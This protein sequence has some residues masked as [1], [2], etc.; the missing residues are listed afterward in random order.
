MNKM[1]I[2]I[3]ERIYQNVVLLALASIFIVSISLSAYADSPQVLMKAQ[4]SKNSVYCCEC[5]TL[6]MCLYSKLGDIAY[7]RP[8]KLPE[9]KCIDK[10]NKSDK[11]VSRCEIIQINTENTKVEKV[12]VGKSEYFRFVVA[13]YVIIPLSD[14]QVVV[15]NS[16]YEIGVNQ[17]RVMYDPFWGEVQGF[18]TVPVRCETKELKFKSMKLPRYGGEST[19]SGCVGDFSISSYLPPGDIIKDKE[20]TAVVE[21]EG[22]GYLPDDCLPDLRKAFGQGVKLKSVS[23]NRQFRYGENGLRTMMEFVCRFV[24]ENGEKIEIGSVSFTFF[25][26]IKKKYKTVES[27]KLT[28]EVTKKGI[29]TPEDNQLMEI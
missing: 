2:K 26:S 12:K 14:G 11:D 20:A 22:E 1:K 18:E 23:E 19:F 4:L 7:V 13:R 24:P 29:R 6:D 10:V 15:T 17:G 27:E 16:E 9:I 8:L 5:L 3:I 25:D 21:I 28:E